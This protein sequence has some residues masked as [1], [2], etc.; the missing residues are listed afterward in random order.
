M[1]RIFAKVQQSRKVFKIRNQKPKPN[2]PKQIKIKLKRNEPDKEAGRGVMHGLRWAL[3]LEMLLAWWGLA[4]ALEHTYGWAGGRSLAG[5]ID[6]RAFD[7]DEV[8]A[9]NGNDDSD[10]DD[11]GK[12]PRGDDG[13]NA[14]VGVLHCV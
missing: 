7:G 12:W 9:G 5:N 4:G 13:D 14:I 11:N 2:K 6:G 1:I 10:D 8:V 3:A